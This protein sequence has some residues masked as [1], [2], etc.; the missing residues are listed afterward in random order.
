MIALLLNLP[1]SLLKGAATA[2]LLSGRYLMKTKPTRFVPG[3]LA[4]ILVAPYPHGGRH[5]QQ[6][7]APEWVGQITP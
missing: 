7:V 5:M 2:S 1:F 3:G 6:H 4:E